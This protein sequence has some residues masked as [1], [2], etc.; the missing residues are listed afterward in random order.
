MSQPQALSHRFDWRSF[1][2]WVGLTVVAFIVAGD[3]HFQTSGP[4]MPFTLQDIDLSAGGGG[5]MFGAVSGLI[6]GALQWVVLKS[7]MTT[8]RLWIT[9]NMIGFGLAHALHDAVPYRP[10]DLPL[11]LVL[12]GIIVGLAQTIAL[13]HALSRPFLWVPVTGFA[14]FLGFQL[15]FAWLTVNRIAGNPLAE[16]TTVG[17]TAGLIIGAITGVAL[18]LLAAD[19]LPTL[20]TSQIHAQK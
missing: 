16:L 20:G 4:R 3:L 13:R 19:N 18:R 8:S 5:F 11:L 6:I 14:W 1:G 10:L 12:D 9:F 2:L 7:W 15:G 17:G